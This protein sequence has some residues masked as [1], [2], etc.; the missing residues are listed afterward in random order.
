MI[1]RCPRCRGTFDEGRDRLRCAGCGAGYEVVGGV[2][3]LRLPGQGWINLAD[4]LAN[5]RRLAAQRGATAEDLLRQVFGARDGWDERRVALRVRQ[6]LEGPERLTGEI[7][8]W[9]AEVIP[10]DGVFLDLGC[11]AGPLLA[12]AALRG[13]C[14]IG[15]D[16]SMTW[17]IVAKR[18]VEEAGGEAVLAAGLAEALPLGDGAVDAALALDVIEHVPD[19]DR[20]LA[21]MDRVAGGQIA[22]ATPNRFSLT[23]E[24]H[25]FVWGVGWLPRPWQ[26]PFVRWRSG[27]DYADTRLMSSFG[28][29]QRLRRNTH[30]A[31]RLLIPPIPREEIARF[32]PLK[33]R[34]ARAYNRLCM[35]HR[36]RWAFLLLAPFFRVVGRKAGAPEDMEGKAIAA[37]ARA[38]SILFSAGAPVVAFGSSAPC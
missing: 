23:P 5:A 31:V 10:P 34:A 22:V 8:G 38:H 7:D 12:A 2:P 36:L 9:L 15:I 35:S 24:P 19:P 27:A 33:A 26:A 1:W 17:L 3:D 11:G 18:L 25:V 30:F 13:R 14:G 4:D 16:V 29:R 6:V 28:L 20:L 37:F 21:E 32:P